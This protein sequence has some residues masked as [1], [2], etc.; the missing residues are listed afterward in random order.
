MFFLIQLFLEV[1]IHTHTY[2]YIYLE[3]MECKSINFNFTTFTV[4]MPTILSPILSI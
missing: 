3:G 1:D 4:I 2:A